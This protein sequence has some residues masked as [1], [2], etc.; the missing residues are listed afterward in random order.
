MRVLHISATDTRGGAARGSFWL[1]RALREAGVDSL[2]LVGRKFSRDERVVALN[3]ATT[4]RVTEGLR[5]AFD[6]LPL[7]GYRKPETFWTIGW[8]PRSLTSAVRD[9]EPDLVH[10][11]WTGGGFMPIRAIQGLPGP[12]VWTL[13]DMWPFTGGC[14]YTTGCT[15]YHKNCGRCPQ[16]HSTRDADLSRAVWERKRKAWNGL[17]LWLVPISTWLADCVRRSSLLGRHPIRVIPNG[18]DGRRFRPIAMAKAR[19][20]WGLAPDKRYILFGALSARHDERKGFAHLAEAAR[21]LAGACWTQRAELI[22]FGD[23][24]PETAPELGLT[25]RFLGHIGDDKRLAQLYAAADVMVVPSLEEAFGKTLIEAMACATPVVAFAS[26][27]PKDIVVHRQTGYLARPFDPADLAKGIAWC[28]DEPRRPEQLGR[29][30]R[31][32]VEEVYDMSVVAESYH[33]LYRS[34][35]ACRQ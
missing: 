25:T 31:H 23:A 17:D 20:A 2:M 14:H 27:G 18:V 3:G 11:H 5:D 24:S 13:R 16:L 32:R 35:L 15:G 1:H 7:Y 19:A 4:A 12:L 22:V 6:Q 30:A 29:K 34:I 9:L 21:I 26:G 33:D 10:L 8:L 28:L